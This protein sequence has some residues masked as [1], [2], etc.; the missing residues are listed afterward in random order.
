VKVVGR[1]EKGAVSLKSDD[2]PQELHDRFDPDQQNERN[3][4]FGLIPP[5][6]LAND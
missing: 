1:D 6:L 3:A 5:R 2:Y 4:F